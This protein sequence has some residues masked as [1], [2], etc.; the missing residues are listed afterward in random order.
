MSKR[1]EANHMN[2]YVLVCVAMN[3]GERIVPLLAT[4]PTEA[5]EHLEHYR[6]TGAIIIPTDE[7]GTIKVLEPASMHLATITQSVYAVA[8]DTLPKGET[9]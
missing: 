3:K 1:E 2:G 4:L 8:K 6:Q 5:K 7:V 9:T